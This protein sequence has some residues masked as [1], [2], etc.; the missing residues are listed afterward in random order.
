MSAFL[1]VLT[2]KGIVFKQLATIVATFGIICLWNTEGRSNTGLEYDDVELISS[3]MWQPL[4]NGKKYLYPP[5]IP[6]VLKNTDE[7][8]TFKVEQYYNTYL[9]GSRVKPHVRGTWP[10]TAEHELKFNNVFGFGQTVTSELLL[11]HAT[12]N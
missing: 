11:R 4:A 12:A 3:V 9:N 7:S 10:K 6:A 5:G 2:A 8:R 1:R